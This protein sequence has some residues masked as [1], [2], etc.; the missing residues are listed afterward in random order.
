MRK[1][2]AGAKGD[3]DGAA[4]TPGSRSYDPCPVDTSGV[5]IPPDVAALT[6]LL[7][8]NTHENWARQRLSDGWRWGPVREDASREHPCLVPYEELPEAERD[9]D[10][11]TALET[12]RLILA[13]GFRVVSPRAEAPSGCAEGR[14]P[15]ASPSPSRP[16]CARRTRS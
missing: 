7:A 6:E 12:V 10:R 3:P 16:G 14:R 4:E 1:K 9:Y 5:E 13:L 15:S 2:A 11:R 8:R